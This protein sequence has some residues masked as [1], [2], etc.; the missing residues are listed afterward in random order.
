MSGI[1]IIGMAAS[2]LQI[3]DADARL[4]SKPFTFTRKIKKADQTI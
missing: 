4:S 3:A 1:E 2:V